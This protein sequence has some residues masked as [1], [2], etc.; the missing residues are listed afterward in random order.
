MK[1]K[2]V[3]LIAVLALMFCFQPAYASEQQEIISSADYAS[4]Y[5]MTVSFQANG[6]TGVMTEA[7]LMSD[8]ASSLPKNTFARTDFTFT[9]WNTKANGHGTAI[10]DQASVSVRPVEDQSAENFKFK[11]GE[12]TGGIENFLQRSRFGK[13]L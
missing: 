7:V 12:G 8:E 11:G 5:Q 10:A 3:S 1:K 6:G 4:A 13:Q 9:G 2:M